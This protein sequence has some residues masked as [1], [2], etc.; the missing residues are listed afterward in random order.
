MIQGCPWLGRKE[1]HRWTEGNWEHP[2]MLLLLLHFFTP[3]HP[4]RLFSLFSPR[5][6]LS[7]PTEVPVSL[8]VHYSAC[9]VQMRE[10]IQ[11]TGMNLRLCC[12][13]RDPQ[14]SSPVRTGHPNNPSLC[15]RGLS[16]LSWSCG[17]TGAV[18]TSLGS[19]SSATP[20]SGRR[21]FS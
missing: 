5:C 14:R 8:S 15:L 11:V 13:G 4:H 7:V 9:P 6:W 1:W 19:L 18:I 21:T 2:V 16:K 20:P 17:R 3:S 12:V 10:V